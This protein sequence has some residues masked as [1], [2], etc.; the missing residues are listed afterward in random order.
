MAQIIV[1]IEKIQKQG[2]RS[3]TPTSA[4]SMAI[5]VGDHYD[6]TP[7]GTGSTIFNT[8]TNTEYTTTNSASSVATLIYEAS[9]SDDYK[10]RVIAGEVTGQKIMKAL[11]ERESLGTTTSGE[12]LWRGNDL[13]AVPSALT[14]T[15][16]IPALDVAGEQLTIISESDADNG[17]TATGVLTVRVE[18]LDATGAEQ[19]TD[20]ILDGTTGVNLFPSD[21]RFINDMYSLTIGSNGVAEGNI[22]IYN[23]ATPALVYNMIYVGGNKSL[24]PHRMV[25]L[26]KTL[27]LM[28]WSVS[29]AQNKRCAFRIRSTDMYGIL[30]PNVFCFKGVSYMKAST[31]GEL[32]IGDMIPALSVVKVSGWAIQAG[33]EGSCGWWGYLIDD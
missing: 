12:D 8:L 9:R 10:K 33:A 30:I 7:N 27:Q 17:A 20:V 1:T 3:W 2:V 13:S 21:V 11:G 16:S 14:S 5:D 22:R 31:S 19:T 32:T 26:G 6:I 28:A 4:T 25:P 15:T 29:E 23:T 24:V 18:Y